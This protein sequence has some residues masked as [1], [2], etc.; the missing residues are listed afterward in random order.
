METLELGPDDRICYDYQKPESDSGAVFVFFNALTGDI[1][2]WESGIAPLLRKAGHGTL[3]YNMRGQ[4]NSPFSPGTELNQKLIVD[5]AVRLIRHIAPPRPV[6]VGL[7]IG[8]LFAANAALAGIECAG[9]V[10]INT[11]RRDGPR[12][13]WINSAVV[14]MAEVGGAELIRDLMSPLIMSEAWQADNRAACL[15]EGGY[16]PI[17]RDSGTYNLLASARGSNWDI[18]YEQLTMPVLVVTGKHDRVFRDLDD[19]A[20]LS[21]RIPNLSQHEFDDAGH[22]VPVESPAKLAE[23]ILK[24]TDT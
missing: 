2:Q 20:T 1:A 23:A 11:L 10:L 13:E 24:F 8:G 19:I 17:D 22:M 12:L 3:A 6:F 16:Q 15:G 21:A 14:R 5:D 9:L 4:A 7:S 18:P